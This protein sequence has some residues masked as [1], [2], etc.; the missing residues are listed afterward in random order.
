M[1]LILRYSISEKFSIA[2][3]YLEPPEPNEILNIIRF[4]NIHKAS[5]YDNISSFSLRLGGKY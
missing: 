4:L 5:D 1:P 2:V 3:N